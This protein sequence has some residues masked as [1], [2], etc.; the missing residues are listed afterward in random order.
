LQ[1]TPSVSTPSTLAGTSSS[2]HV[3]DWTLRSK[4][5]LHPLL[6]YVDGRK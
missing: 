6:H 4:P 1:M 5:P 3:V 2:I